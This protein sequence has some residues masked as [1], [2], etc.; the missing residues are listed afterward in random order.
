MS[1]NKYGT[2]L[3]A[4]AAAVEPGPATD[5]DR[6]AARAAAMTAPL[7]RPLAGVKLRQA[8]EVAYGGVCPSPGAGCCAQRAGTMVVAHNPNQKETS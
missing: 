5:R 7:Y 1:C 6:E 2:D 4:L 8:C 3:N